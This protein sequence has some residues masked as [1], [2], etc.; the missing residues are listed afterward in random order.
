MKD[1]S[2]SSESRN[3][4]LRAAASSAS[5]ETQRIGGL[6]IVVL[7]LAIIAMGGWGWVRFRRSSVV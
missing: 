3:G 2:Q 7:L 1:S 4:V 6:F 5:Q